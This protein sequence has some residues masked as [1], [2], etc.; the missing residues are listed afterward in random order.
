MMM[1]RLNPNPSSLWSQTPSGLLR[2]S[3]AVSTVGQPRTRWTSAAR[4]GSG[5]QTPSMSAS[6]SFEDI[7]AIDQPPLARHADAA[8]HECGF[9][10]PVARPL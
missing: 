1:I 7:F 8:K 10:Q 5:C 2:L 4:P 6:K 9:R 3:S